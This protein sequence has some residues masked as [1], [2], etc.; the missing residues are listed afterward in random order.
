MPTWLVATTGDSAD[1]Q[2]PPLQ[3]LVWCQDWQRKQESIVNQRGK[4]RSVCPTNSCSKREVERRSGNPIYNLQCTVHSPSAILTQ[5]NTFHAWTRNAILPQGRTR[6]GEGAK[7]LS[8]FES[9]DK[10][11]ERQTTEY[12]VK[13]LSI[14]TVSRVCLASR[15]WA[16]FWKIT[17]W[18]SCTQCPA[19]DQSPQRHC[20]NW[21]SIGRA[22]F[23]L[24]T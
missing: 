11:P 2:V 4:W 10:V 21:H 7:I 9:V 6:L 22:C 19:L 16:I 5:S 3:K 1:S 24:W 12:L 15:M 13:D 8:L 14:L 20:K 18:P 23:P 17:Q